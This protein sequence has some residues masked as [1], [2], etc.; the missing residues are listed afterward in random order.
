L[1]IYALKP[2]NAFSQA[3]SGIVT[4]YRNLFDSEPASL[5]VLDDKKNHLLSYLSMNRNRV[6]LVDFLHLF[7]FA[8]FAVAQPLYD[9]LGQ[10]PEFF[11]SH[12]AGPALIIGIVFVLSVGV[13]LGLVLCE[14]AASI[15][16]ERIRRSVHWVFV[17]G[18]ATLVMLPPVKRWI[19]GNDLVIVGVA[20]LASLSF[21][22]FYVRWQGIRLFATVLSPV[23]LAFPL[24]F[25]LLTPVSRL[26]LPEVIDAQGDIEIENPV[27]VV[28]VVFDEFNITALLDAA[29]RIDPVRFPNFAALAAESWWFQNAVAASVSTERAVPAIL[30]GRQPQPDG[31]LTPTATDHPQN[32]FTMLGKHYGLNVFESVTTL[33]PDTL[34]RVKGDA[35]PSRR[36]AAVFADV[37]MIYLHLITPPQIEQE[38]PSLDAQW[39]GFG[40]ALM[41][42]EA[43]TEYGVGSRPEPPVRGSN[44]RDSHLA[45]FLSQIKEHVNPGLHFFHVLLPHVTYEYLASGHQYSSE[46][47]PFPEG[48]IEVREWIGEDPLILTAYHRYL[49]QIGYL[50]RFLG[51][52]RETLEASRLYDN[53]LIILTADHGVAFQQ[54]LS[55]RKVQNGNERDILKVPMI[56]K[57]PGQR[58]GRISERLVS[59]LDVLP[60]IADVLGV[61]AQWVMDGRAMLSEEDPPR[62]EIEIPGEGRF[63]VKALEGFS[64]L[65]WQFEHFGMHT[66]LDRLVPKGPYPALIGQA[67]TDLPVGQSSALRFHSED[68][69]YLE[70]VNPKSGFLPALF[71]AHI[72]GTDDSNLPIAIGLNGRIWGTTTTSEWDGKRNYF[73]ALFPPA[74]FKEG[75]NTVG[76]YQ[77]DESDGKL[78]PIGWSDEGQ[79]IRLSY[80]SSGSIKL[81]LSD[82]R[83]IPVNRERG[84]IQG[85]LDTVGFVGNMLVLSGWAGDIA[86]NRPASEVLI[87]AGEELLSRVEPESSRQDVA[88]AHQRQ[89]LL[90]SGFHALVP[91]EVVKSH[92][93]EIR[94]ILVSQAE[95]TL[96][97]FLSNKQKDVVLAAREKGGSGP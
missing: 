5:P 47:K 92:A 20:V 73:S 84:V 14:F 42:G 1:P 48:F 74:A 55:R 9:L 71:R 27:P 37:A 87:F 29:G 77:I 17:F 52:L 82:G 67:L 65:T 12:K 24:W 91:V 76:V 90:H 2:F 4:G 63:T 61:K 66:S 19:S 7:V 3:T 44:N 56:V 35:V 13:A 70:H 32:L 83:E 64:R 16:G 86:E 26:V 50:D 38:L 93:S 89:G 33:C 95:K 18:L 40:G 51:Q 46:R 54:G 41:G 8:G 25:L 11:V 53:A 10:N 59:G 96:E 31:P 22:V 45:Y 39:T 81:M 6:V 97:L 57:L 72:L 23:V 68:V 49:Q 75:K 78:M 15:F 88:D 34:C 30:T 28:L 94:V 58:E 21:V 80:D 43:S 62:T 69:K 60:T 85:N 36:Y 79:M